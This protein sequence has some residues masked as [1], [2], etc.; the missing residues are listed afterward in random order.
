[1][2]DLPDCDAWFQP[3]RAM[4]EDL[5]AHGWYPSGIAEQLFEAGVRSP[6][7]PES[8]RQ[9]HLDTF[10]GLI[11]YLLKKPYDPALA[12]LRGHVRKLEKEFARVH[13]ELKDAQVALRNYGKPIVPDTR[14]ILR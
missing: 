7:L 3:H 1:M 2:P 6:F 4:I 8:E 9:R 13:Q 11:K 5:H 10:A 14:E 12:K